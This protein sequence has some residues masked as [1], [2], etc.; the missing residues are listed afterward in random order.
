MDFALDMRRWNP[1]RH[2]QVRLPGLSR[3]Y[4]MDGV[5]LPHGTAAAFRE[6]GSIGGQ[7]EGA[8]EKGA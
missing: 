4:A 2:K 8:S 1:K 3:F 7:D 5:C 6:A